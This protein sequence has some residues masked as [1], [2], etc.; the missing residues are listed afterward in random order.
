MARQRQATKSFAWFAAFALERFGGQSRGFVAT[1]GFAKDGD[2]NVVARQMI[3]GCKK[4]TF[5]GNAAQHQVRMIEIG[6][7]KSPRR[8]DGGM[9]ALNGLL[10]GGEVLADEDVTVSD[11]VEGIH[12]AT[13][14]RFLSHFQTAW[15]AP[16]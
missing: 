16:V 4:A 9:D 15:E 11:L 6:R 13:I 12:T 1:I 2:A 3:G 10:G 5:V 14:L 7:K 8:F